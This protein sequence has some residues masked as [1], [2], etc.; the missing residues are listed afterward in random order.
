M[1]TGSDKAPVTKQATAH[2]IIRRFKEVAYSRY[3]ELS[4]SLPENKLN[5]FRC[6]YSYTKNAAKI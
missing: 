3:F 2:A 4:D 1:V 5:T 6:Y